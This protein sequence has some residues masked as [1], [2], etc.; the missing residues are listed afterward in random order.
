MLKSRTRFSAFVFGEANPRVESA[1]MEYV[2]KRTAGVPWASEIKQLEA[3]GRSLGLQ[4]RKTM[5]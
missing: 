4:F 5:K 2:A 3:S 1:S